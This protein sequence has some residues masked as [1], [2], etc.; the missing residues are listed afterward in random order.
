MIE[1]CTRHK[2]GFNSD[3]DPV[4]PQCALGRLDAPPSPKV[5]QLTLDVPDVID[6]STGKPLNLRTRK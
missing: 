2:I 1:F 6:Q 5:D 3:L 4:C